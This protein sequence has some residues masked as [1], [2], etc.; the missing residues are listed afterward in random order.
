MRKTVLE[1]T[2][3]VVRKILVYVRQ[4]SLDQLENNKGSRSH[5]L[6]QIEIAR[7]LGFPEELI[8]IIED[9]GLTG[10]AAAHRPQYQYMLAEIRAGRVAYVIASDPSRI[11]RDA[12]EWL[13]FI[14]LCG[15]HDVLLMLDGKVMN[16]KKGDERF[17]AGIVAM[18]AEYDNWR[19]RE[20]SMNGRLARFKDGKAVT[21]PPVGYVWGPDGTWLKDDRPGVQE[22][23]MAHFRAVLEVRS[24]RRAVRLLRDKGVDSPRRTAGGGVAW[25]PPTTSTLG[26]MLHHPAYV[27]DIVFAHHRIDPLRERDGRGHYRLVPL[28]EDEILVMHDH[29]EPYLTREEQTEISELL[30]R[31]TWSNSHGVIGPGDALAQGCLRCR[32]HNLWL[33]RSIQKQGS[34]RPRGVYVCTGDTLE[35]GTQCGLIPGWVIDKPL[36][37]AAVAR[38]QPHALDELRTVMQRAE[39]DAHAEERRSRDTLHR[40]RLEVDDLQFRFEH[41]NLKNWA[42]KEALEEKLQRKRVELKRREEEQRTAPP[43]RVFLADGCFEELRDLCQNLGDLL[44]APSTEPRDRKEL[45]RIMVDRVVVEERTPEKVRFRIVWQDGIEDSVHE[46]LLFPYAHRVIGEMEALGATPEAIAARLNGDGVLTKYQTRWTPPAVKRQV[47]RMRTKERAQAVPAPD[48]GSRC[49]KV[50]AAQDPRVQKTRRRT[51]VPA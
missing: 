42:V 44:D 22:S 23:I 8:E 43:P 24:L 17:F 50:K 30:S 4:S 2:R 11:S 35:G 49:E 33:M 25:S 40:L 13:A 47:A 36:L 28:A 21:P 1:G 48:A 20:S 26:R 18:A 39:F 41:V 15:A 9:A 45:I 27:G 32:K 7:S 51:K 38:L 46:V 16:P 19:R 12:K 5:Q 14:Y 34:T 6:R 31:N 29:H 37:A 3:N 10:S